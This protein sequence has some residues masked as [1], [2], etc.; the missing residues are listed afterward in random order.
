MTHAPVRR[1][2]VDIPE[3]DMDDLGRRV[4]AT[5]WPSKE[6][7]Q[8]RSQGVQVAALQGLARYW[9]TDYDFG[10][11]RARLN[12][13]AVEQAPDELLAALTAFLAPY[14]DGEDSE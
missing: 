4:A 11:A 6:L 7:V 9:T 1:F 8:D 5:R 10:R 2:R 14:R 13:H 12:A 3:E